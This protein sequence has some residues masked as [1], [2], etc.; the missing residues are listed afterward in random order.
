MANLKPFAWS[1]SAL[2][3]F[4]TCP[5]GYAQK[6]V[7]KNF[8]DEMSAE[9]LKGVEVHNRLE[10]RLMHGQ[11]LPDDM[12]YEKWARIIEAAKSGT[13]V[14]KCEMQIALNRNFQQTSWF[15]K[16]AWARAIIDVLLVK[17]EG[18]TAYVYDWKTGKVKTDPT[19]LKLFVAVL[20]RVYP[21]IERYVTKFVWLKYDKVTPST[22]E[23][24]MFM[25]EWI[26]DIWREILPRVKR[27]EEAYN[28]GVFPMKPN[29]L[30]GK[31]CPVLTCPHNG[32]HGK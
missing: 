23:G 12:P 7:Y 17:E 16:D 18:T 31:Y 10:K 13:D 4:E 25:R 9:G 1:Y 6:K 32:R 19:Q 14:L 2:N 30:C 22:V 20:N 11:P 26:P 27:M 29:G 15:G 24:D 5:H 3:D 21:D 8:K 28:A